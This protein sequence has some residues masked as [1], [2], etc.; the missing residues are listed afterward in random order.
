M[1]SRGGNRGQRESGDPGEEGSPRVVIM[2]AVAVVDRRGCRGIA[3]WR[4][5]GRRGAGGSA[6]ELYGT[7][8]LDSVVRKPCST[9]SLSAVRAK[10]GRFSS[11]R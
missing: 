4:A 7:N 5:I 11:S 2:R 8:A 9:Q 3:R 10:A 6:N 1:H